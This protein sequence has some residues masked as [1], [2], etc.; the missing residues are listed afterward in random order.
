VRLALVP[1]PAD[2][3]VVLLLVELLPHAASKAAAA[4][5]ATA[6][7]PARGVGLSV[8][9]EV[10]SRA[11]NQPPP[12]PAPNSEFTAELPPDPLELL[13][14]LVVVVVVVVL[15]PESLIDVADTVPLLFFRPR[16]TTESPGCS[17]C[18]PTLRLLVSLVAEESVTLTVLPELSER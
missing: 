1:V 15:A 14:L 5:A 12:A 4:S 3:E 18:F 17:A 11:V 6:V 16:I 13:L 9:I 2:A 10:L 8:V 7:R